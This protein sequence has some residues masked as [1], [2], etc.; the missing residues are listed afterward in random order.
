M[1]NLLTENPAVDGVF[2]ANDLMAVGA[3]TALR[4]AGRRVPE[5]VAVVGFDDSSA[6]LAA[7]P[8]LTTIR[9]PLE[10]MAAESARLLLSRVEDRTMR[11]SSVIYEPTLVIR[12][13]A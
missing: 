7:A 1:Q 2:V 11:P 9:H 12:A 3:L 13:S 10:D 6:A 8:P 5:D 4:E